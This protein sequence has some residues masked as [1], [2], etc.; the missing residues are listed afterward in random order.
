MPLP[1]P[2]ANHLRG[3][4]L[5]DY[6]MRREL[7]LSTRITTILTTINPHYNQPELDMF[8]CP[9][10]YRALRENGYIAPFIPSLIHRTLILAYPIL[11]AVKSCQEVPWPQAEIPTPHL[12]PLAKLNRVSKAF[13]VMRS[14]KAKHHTAH[15]CHVPVACVWPLGP[16]SHLFSPFLWPYS[17]CDAVQDI[18]MC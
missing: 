11:S 5:A 10:Q 15:R 6:V 2:P 7:Y 9:L 1:C 3:S 4:Y 16:Q 8:S 18:I 12:L 17:V 14:Q 13:S